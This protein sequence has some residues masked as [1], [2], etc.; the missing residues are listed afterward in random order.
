[1][2]AFRI[3][4]LGKYNG[5]EHRTATRIGQLQEYNTYEKRTAMRKQ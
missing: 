4:Q 2:I 1:M 3:E 5:Y